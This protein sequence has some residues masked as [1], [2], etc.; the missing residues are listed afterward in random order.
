MNILEAF[1]KPFLETLRW[2]LLWKHAETVF[3][4]FNKYIVNNVKNLFLIIVVKNNI[5]NIYYLLL[6]YWKGF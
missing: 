2:F 6:I 3:F 4:I 5:Y 1:Y